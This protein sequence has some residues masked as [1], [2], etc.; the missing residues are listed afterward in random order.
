MARPL[1]LKSYVLWLR[2]EFDHDGRNRSGIFPEQIMPER[3]KCPY[4]DLRDSGTKR[5][6]AGLADERITG[7]P[8]EQRRR[9]HTRQHCAQ[10]DAD[11]ALIGDGTPNMRG[12]GSRVAPLTAC[13]LRV[14]R[15]RYLPPVA[16]ERRVGIYGIVEFGDGGE[17]TTGG[18]LSRGGG[19]SR[20]RR[21]EGR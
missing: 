8:D 10:V 6:A 1:I 5:L 20:R 3:G 16:H 14:V 4:V 2:Q 9:L 12:Y 19:R 17:P 7:T 21:G 15:D 18:S 11:E 13:K